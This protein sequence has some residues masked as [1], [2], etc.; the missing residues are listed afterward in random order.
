[1]AKILENTL[2]KKI[3]CRARRLPDTDKVGG[4]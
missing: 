1:M 4:S 2:V 3:F